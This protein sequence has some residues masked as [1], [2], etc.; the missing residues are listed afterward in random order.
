[1]EKIRFVGQTRGLSAALQALRRSRADL[2]DP[3]RPTEPGVGPTGVGKT[4]L[5][6]ET[7][8]NSATDLMMLLF[9]F[10]YSLL[11]PPNR[12]DPRLTIRESCDR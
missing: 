11:P 2:K 4:L 12:N 10:R 9:S 3:K 8:Q 1:M 7:L 5:G 6:K